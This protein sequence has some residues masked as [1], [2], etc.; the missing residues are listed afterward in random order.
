MTCIGLIGHLHLWENVLENLKLDLASTRYGTVKRPTGIENSPEINELDTGHE[1]T[2]KLAVQFLKT[3]SYDISIA[4]MEKK[5][6]T[7][8]S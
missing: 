6:R 3:K 7:P 2:K 1:S 8:L 4:D 5:K